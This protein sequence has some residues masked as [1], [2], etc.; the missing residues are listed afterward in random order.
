MWSRG[1]RGDGEMVSQMNG[2]VKDLCLIPM[3]RTEVAFMYERIPA[4]GGS[5]RVTAMGAMAPG[6]LRFLW[7]G[8]DCQSEE[9]TRVSSKKTLYWSEAIT[10]PPKSS[11]KKT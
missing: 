7:K 8:F 4:A 1:A 2:K 11:S 6:R 9:T 10:V 5:K 3:D